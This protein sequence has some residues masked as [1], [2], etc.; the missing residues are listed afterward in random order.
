MKPPAFDKISSKDRQQAQALRQ[1]NM[2]L[3][4]QSSPQKTN[5]DI[6]KCEPAKT[7]A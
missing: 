4:R 1:L 6:E 2:A 5:E 3:Q 7:Q